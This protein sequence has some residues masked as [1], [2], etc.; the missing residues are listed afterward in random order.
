M[1]KIYR[2]IGLFAAVAVCPALA[3]AQDV[4]I[5]FE[6]E[7][8]YKALGVYDTW[9]A[10]PFRTGRLE[11][12]VAVIDNFI[13]DSE[14]NG[15]ARILGVQ[16]SRFGSN[17]F[18]ARIDL[19]E[20]MTID[21]SKKYY[22]HVMINKPTEGRVM[23]IGLGKRGDREGQSNEVEQFWSYPVSDIKTGEWFDAVFPVKCNGGVE[24][25]SL[26][27]VPDCEAPHA[28][29]GDFAAYIDEIVVN[30]QL[31]PRF[32]LGDYPVNF[33]TD[34]GWGRSDRRISGVVLSGG[35]NG[36]QSITIPASELKGYNERFTTPFKAKAGDTLTPSISYV[37]SWMHG[38]AYIDRGNDGAFSYGVDSDNYLDTSTDLVSYS[39]YR[40]GSSGNGRNSAGNVVYES[41]NGF[42]TMSMPSFTV[43]ADLAP[44]IYRMRY[45]VDWNNIDPG[46]CID[47][48][49]NILSNGGGVVDVLLNIH[50]DYITVNQDNR[51][52]DVLMAS[53]G[54]SVKGDRV[55]FGQPLK[56]KM[57]PSNG[58]S[59]NGI[60]VRHGYNLTGDS[61]IKSNPQYQDTYFYIDDFDSTDDTFT[62]PADVMDGDVLIEGLFVE[63]SQ[64]MVKKTVTYNIVFGGDIIDTQ[65]FTVMS[66]S[67]YPRPEISSE[68]SESYYR[69][70]GF[71]EGTTSREDEVITLTLEQ[72]LPFEVSTDFNNAAW[73]N[74]TLTNDKCF[75]T[76]NPDQSYIDL[77]E[78][79]TAIPDA[80]D[81]NAQWAFIGD[82]LHGFMI[83]NRGAGEGMVLSSSQNTSANTG[84][85]TY[86][87][88]TSVP[89][90]DNYNTY[91]I[92]TVGTAGVGIDGFYLHQLGY[93]SNRMNSRDG[94]LAYWTGGADGG[95]TFLV[96]L[97]EK[98][99][100]IGDVSGDEA[101]AEYFNLQ[102]V[103]EDGS[104]L[105]PGFHIKRQGTKVTKILVR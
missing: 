104:K 3:V 5:D 82:V 87:V 39:L 59:Y 90:P 76:H 16:R 37:G 70:T 7:A 52:G 9:E 61:L 81:Y 24:I 71:P 64:G 101:P 88:M 74:M 96:T 94:R 27:V 47:A 56:I 31:A 89:V 46:G 65:M 19:N 69:I 72:L 42:N 80:D 100:G 91:W 32:G 84:G 45:K 25:H 48:S 29:T 35:D 6:D 10:S 97:V 99:V 12:N 75:L 41:N 14:T 98:T 49:N 53:T 43:P 50:N 83:I 22:A 26:V 17:T 60:R 73:Y 103:R 105:A 18:G 57:N 40:Q 23:L 30:D 34:S 68:A 28:L 85:N 15:T 66:G 95:S 11:G 21:G 78:S 51:N 62:I 20:P 54:E 33:S 77:S 36:T 55:P 8:G 92:P 86:P 38:Y 102:G 1:K 44:G 63:A 93:V 4:A 2:H 67:E 79:T 13:G 58:F